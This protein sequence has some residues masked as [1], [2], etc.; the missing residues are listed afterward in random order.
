MRAFV[1][2]FIFISLINVRA[3]EGNSFP[4]R[5]KLVVGIVVDQMRQEYLYRYSP[6]F[7]E[8]GFKRLIREGY[9]LTNAHYNY[10]PT[11]TGP[12]HASVYTGTTPAYHG[13][14]GNN[15][16][17]KSQDVM[18]NCVEDRSQ[19]TV[20]SEKGNGAVSPW[21]LRS[22]TITDELE[23]ATQ[24]RAK[25]IGISIKD[26]GAVLPAGHTPDCA[27]WYDDS[28]G[29]FITSTFYK[30]AL[31][32]WMDRFN[33]RN[34]ADNYLNEKWTTVY[35]IEQYKESG[36]DDTPYEEAPKGKEKAVF[37]YDL[38]LLRKENGDFGLLPST[39]FGNDILT[40][41]AIAAIDGEQMGKDE[42]TDFLAISY[43][44]TDIIGH[45]MGPNSI[46]VEDTYIR[47]D[48]NIEE[49]IQK[50]DKEIG[51]GQYVMF[52]TSD[53][54]VVE[55]PEYLK[56]L[57]ILHAESQPPRS[58]EKELNEYL[59]SYYP[60]KKFIK[61]ISNNQIFFDH[62]LFGSD[63]KSSGVE[64]MVI[65]E[66]TRNYLMGLSG[67][68][69]VYTR[70]T[71]NNA[72][73]NDGGMRGLVRRGF[74]AVRSGDLAI[75]WEPGW[76]QGMGTKGTSHGSAYTYDT[77]VPMIFFGF[78]VKQGSSANYYSITDIAPTLSTILQIKFPNA[79][80]G[81]P[82]VEILK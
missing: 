77:H 31:P 67:V 5:P 14:I 47:L 64:Y 74:H 23:L 44:S 13:I 20:G 48:K 72:D 41:L 12:G 38:K 3:Q 54:G 71:L 78:G 6:K 37:P 42:W 82:I 73:Y 45:A 62:S 80:T 19:K 49:L 79:N 29:K 26:R 76:I 68:A 70:Q 46:E 75:V 53:H 50:L 65:S 11:F 24:R 9:M 58:F 16:Y 4:G 39:P 33:A 21:R 40:Q 60:D 55:V 32:V 15:W 8:G 57:K 59:A 56:D 25:V 1:F 27:Y 7:G 2:L 81:Q 17:D 10:V 35:P 28:T 22:S 43:S 34:L 30:K 52:L 66:L 18:V 69:D 51:Q 61:K 36:P 63:P